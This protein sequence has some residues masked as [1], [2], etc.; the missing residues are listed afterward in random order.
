MAR[1]PVTP[2]LLAILDVVATASPVFAADPTPA[3][4]ARVARPDEQGRRLLALFEGT[5]AHDPAA[6]L[7]AWTHATGGQGGPGKP[8]RAVIA[9][10]NPAMI[11]ESRVFDGAELAF[12]LD[13]A[14]NRLRWRARL[15]S[16]D[17]TL[18]ALAE[19]LVLTDGAVEEPLDGAKVLRLGRVGSPVAAQAPLGLA[20]ASSRD[21]LQIAMNPVA[22][23][24]ASEARNGLNL[25]LNPAG[26]RALTSV[27]G[28][29]AATAV[30]AL[31]FR[32]AFGWLSLESDT[33]HFDLRASP[34]P[35]DRCGRG[36]D[37][38]WLDVIPSR[39]VLAAGAIALDGAETSLA[40]AFAVLDRIDRSDPA[41]AGLA[42]LRTRLNLMAAVAGVRPEVDLWPNLRGL[43]VAL[44]DDGRGKIGGGVAALHTVDSDAAAR[45]SETVLP[46]LSAL[47]VRPGAK[48]VTVRSLP[49]VAGKPVEASVRGSC[50]LVGW[51]EGSLGR[52]FEAQDDPGRSA[53]RAIRAA[54]D[55]P[56]PQRAGAIWPGRWRSVAAPGSPLALALEEAPPIVWSGR[57]DGAAS[58]DVL[59]W[60]GLH[61]IVDRWLERL[62][63]ERPPHP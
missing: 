37:P 25:Q 48:A 45:V 8:I 10:L 17:G 5:R 57:T 36:L 9:A 60:S 31:G 40:W 32:E 56:A 58:R 26:L 42:P 35:G 51:G 46:R 53:G 16:D 52:V 41:R 3:V 12:G 34:G 30:D 7:A 54:W 19:A 49:S 11:G 1:C 2:I 28:R 50:V 13:P 33:L 18:N 24:T 47:Y 4:T 43:T 20:L 15:P 39:G 63:L 38:G 14:T 22:V 29:R 21:W 59:T 6:A 55:G 23:P 61:G 27:P 44:L 62:P